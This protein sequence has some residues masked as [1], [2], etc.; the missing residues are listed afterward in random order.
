MRRFVSIVLAL[1]L[2]IAAV[3]ADRVTASVSAAGLID[4][5]HYKRAR[6]LVAARLR[7]NPADAYAYF[8]QSKVKGAFGDVAGAIAAAERAVAL[9]PH[10]ADFHGQLAEAYAYMAERSS[11]IKGIAYVRMMKKEIAAA[12]ALR[13]HH[14]DTLLVQMMFSWKAPAL[15]GGDRKKA[16]AVAAE[17]VQ[18]DPAWGY[19]AQARLGQDGPHD[20][21]IEN[22]LKQ[23][24]RADG[25]LY[26]A[27]NELANFYC[28]EADRPNPA[29]AEASARRLLQLDAGR[30]GAYNV[31][32]SVYAAGRRWAELDAVLEEA[33]SAAP[34]DLAPY[35]FAAKALLAGRYELPR[36]ERYL[37]KYLTA[38]PE[39]REPPVSQARWLLASAYEKDGRRPDAVRELEAALRLKPD[40]DAARKD[41][42][43]LR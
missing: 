43:R 35:Y 11:W 7:D 42:K 29:A 20:A 31:L 9:E 37:E 5:G 25:S 24:V 41:L 28:C 15:A 40:F 19:L 12:L 16:P 2:P 38:E 13:P 21:R 6:A 34:D 3:A 1:C 26:R 36:A 32:A 8:L 23:A 18:N 17:I 10:N 22:L 4:G 33:Q 14:T 39:G 30:A 27:G